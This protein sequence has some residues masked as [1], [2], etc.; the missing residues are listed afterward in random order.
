[1]RYM[2]SKNRIAKY[3]LPIILK[4]RKENQYYVEPFVGG[5]NM[6]DKVQGK[7]I[8]AD[9][10][11]YLIEALI[12]IRDTPWLI[13]DVITEEEYQIY[14]KKMITDGMTGFVGF[15]MSFGGKWFAGYRRDFA[16]T[17][18]DFENM[19]TQTRRAKVNAIRQSK[20]MGGIRFVNESYKNLIIPNNSLIYCD[21]PYKG[22]TGYKTDFNHEEF[23]DW[24][25]VKSKEGHE[26]YVSEYDAPDDFECVWSG[27]L[28]NTISRKSSRKECE[29]LFKLKQVG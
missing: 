5:A 25:R 7:R 14:K 16:G 27:E 28:S 17:K 1:M 11:G 20:L 26:V 22:V 19:K 24:C 8:G 18:G 9:I 6:I 15:A 13:P 21:P 29:R 23:W 3:L 10:N 2:G 4:N 12:L